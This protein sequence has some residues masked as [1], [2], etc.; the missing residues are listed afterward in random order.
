MARS[1]IGQAQTVPAPLDPSLIEDEFLRDEP[2]GNVL[3]GARASAGALTPDDVEAALRIKARYIVAIEDVDTDAL[4]SAAY[5]PGY[6]RSYASFLGRS[7][8]L[9]PE[10]VLAKFNA[11]LAIKSKTAAPRPPKSRSSQRAAVSAAKA[12]QARPM[13]K[14]PLATKRGVGA[15][16]GSSRA[17]PMVVN[18][19][20]SSSP[21]WSKII[22]FVTVLASVTVVAGLSYGAWNILHSA[23]QI[24]D[25][26]ERVVTLVDR[27]DTLSTTLGR[28]SGVTRPSI[29]AYEDGGV[30][31][32]LEAP[33]TAPKDGP[34]VD[35]AAGS[36][37]GAPA[38]IPALSGSADGS[39]LSSAVGDVQPGGA[40]SAAGQS[41]VLSPTDDGG[42][43]AEVEL[44]PAPPA[45]GDLGEEAVGRIPGIPQVEA[46]PFDPGSNPLTG[47]D[48]DRSVPPG[49]VAA[50]DLD[51][52]SAG[53]GATEPATAQSADAAPLAE[54][55][56]Q[57]VG[58]DFAIHASGEIWVR[59][60]D[61][62]DA[63]VYEG[64]LAPGALRELPVGLEGMQIKT[65]NAGLTYLVVFGN[66]Y[67]PIDGMGQVRTVPLG[68]QSV[69]ENL[70]LS[71]DISVE[72]QSNWQARRSVDG[73]LVTDE[74]PVTLEADTA[75][76]GTLLP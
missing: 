25:D 49:Q 45:R 56:T 72:V 71:T 69:V 39:S 40:V 42:W 22:P 64:I 62:T 24:S 54:T 17:V 47:G 50:L 29:D 1:E 44:T 33:K 65:G 37:A 13:V 63:V 21:S 18:R 23:Q 10:Q 41:S 8:P 75:P 57:P 46:A 31:T 11:E 59:V 48:G 51:G 66:A 7:L 19:P 6:V 14:T 5:L 3:R 32:Q 38:G 15:G 2:L 53:R 4:P 55:V 28:T 16:Y 26:G 34:I 60:T 43:V 35:L 67:G 76:A 70:P 20:Q 74:T 30:L 36:P 12:V 68:M 52:A 58:P 9:T 73:S 27:R 61:V